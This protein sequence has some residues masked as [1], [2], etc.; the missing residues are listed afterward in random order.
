MLNSAYESTLSEGISF[1]RK[2]VRLRE[3]N[4]QNKWKKEG[5]IVWAI[6]LAWKIENTMDD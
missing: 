1:L 3:R 5:W 2:H 6:V 4:Y